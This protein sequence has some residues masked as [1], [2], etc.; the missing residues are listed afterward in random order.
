MPIDFFQRFDFG[1]GVPFVRCVLVVCCESY[2]ETIN[3][4]F[5]APGR[6]TKIVPAPPLS[7]GFP[8]AP[9]NACIAPEKPAVLATT[10][11][12]PPPPEADPAGVELMNVVMS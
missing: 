5:V 3:S 7:T 1:A 2:D 9:A 11:M 12:R 4:P 8:L 6:F 10:A